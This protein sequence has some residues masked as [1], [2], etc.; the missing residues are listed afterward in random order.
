MAESESDALP[1]GDTPILFRHDRDNIR[2]YITAKT[3]CQAYFSTGAIG[4]IIDMFGEDKL[5]GKKFENLF[6]LNIENA[7]LPIMTRGK[8]HTPL[9][10]GISGI[11]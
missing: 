5:T 8:V 6:A 2:Y 7:T 11:F 9:Y 3:E 1:L 10:T 4:R